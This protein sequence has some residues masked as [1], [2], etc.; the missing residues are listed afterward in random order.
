MKNKINLIPKV[1]LILSIPIFLLLTTFQ[2]VVFDMDYFEKK[3]Q[4][5]NITQVTGMD[6]ESLMTVTEELLNYLEGEREDIVLKEKINGEERQVFRE[7]EL[8][9]LKDVQVLF[10]KG[11]LIRNVSLI[12]ILISLFWLFIFER[13]KIPKTFI[14]SSLVTIITMIVFVVLISIDFYKYFTYFHEILF[15][16]DLWLLNPKTEVLIQMYPL[17]FFNSISMKIIMFFVAELIIL[18]I[19]GILGNKFMKKRRMMF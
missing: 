9:H 11:F 4:Q 10:D 2:L 16:N 13:N 7:R 12:L 8:L 15:T 1:I 6:E 14:L 18:F 3:Y 17:D 5:Y 19:L